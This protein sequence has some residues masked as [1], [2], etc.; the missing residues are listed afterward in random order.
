MNTKLW[1]LY[2]KDE[3]GQKTIAAFTFGFTEDFEVIH[4]GLQ[5]VFE[6]TGGKQCYIEHKLD[7]VARFCD[8]LLD[9]NIP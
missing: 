2:K 3:D 8:M 9:E 6:L 5:Y 4:D 1:K 7:N